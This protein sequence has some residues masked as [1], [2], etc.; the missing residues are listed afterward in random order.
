METIESR[1]SPMFGHLIGHDSFV[2]TIIE[3]KDLGLASC[4]KKKKRKTSCHNRV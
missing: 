3:G 2:K 1:T 4:N